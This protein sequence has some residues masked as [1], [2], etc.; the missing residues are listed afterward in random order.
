MEEN[1]WM[2]GSL[3]EDK[4][5]YTK[6]RRFNY[7]RHLFLTLWGIYEDNHFTLLYIDKL[8]QIAGRC[9]NQEGL[10]SETIIYSTKTPNYSISI[11]S[12]EKKVMRDACHL[13]TLYDEI[14]YAHKNFPELFTEN[15][16]ITKDDILKQS[17]KK[18]LGY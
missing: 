11:P 9:R 13:I 2:I 7:Q 18:L 4:L 6:C 15:T 5:Q 8:Q 16:D 17:K 12:V 1:I 10:L 14:I 3:V